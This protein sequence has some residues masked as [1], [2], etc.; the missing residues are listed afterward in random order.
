[1]F[2]RWDGGGRER[3]R[4]E[5]SDPPITLGRAAGDKSKTKNQQARYRV[6]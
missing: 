2:T 4:K 3:A 1:M 6:T 5:N